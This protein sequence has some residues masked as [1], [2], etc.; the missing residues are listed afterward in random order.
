MEGTEQ[1]K[2]GMF[3]MVRFLYPQGQ[4]ITLI[5]G[6]MEINTNMSDGEN[7]NFRELINPENGV[8]GVSACHGS[9]DGKLH[10]EHADETKHS[11][12]IKVPGTTS[13]T[14]GKLR[15]HKVPQVK[16]VDI[17]NQHP[18]YLPQLLHEH[19]IVSI[20]LPQGFQAHIES[21]YFKAT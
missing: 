13:T 3:N 5:K 6:N 21:T 16:L 14:K 18:D 20:R 1:E 9:V 8:L 17:F 19:N 10:T 12:E 2:V 4:Y 11:P 15:Y 7:C